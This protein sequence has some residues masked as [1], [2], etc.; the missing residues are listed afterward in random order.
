M[1][2]L[3]IAVSAWSFVYGLIHT[4]QPCEDKAIFG[5]HTFGVAK[6]SA[7]AFK[8]VGIYALGLMTVNN[9]IGF[10]FSILGNFF[11][12]IP[13][14]EYFVEYLSPVLSIFLGCY[15]YYRLVKLNRPDNHMA[16][17]LAM[18]VRKNLL[19]VF[20]LG[21]ITGIPPCP[22][23]F[24]IYFQA[25]TAAGGYLANGVFHVLW[26]SL[27]TVSGLMVLTLIIRSFKRLERLRENQVLQKI[28]M[29]ILI[30]FGVASLVLKFFGIEFFPQPEPPIV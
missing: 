19:G 6:N 18:K 9:V 10:G 4:I 27:G 21:I 15:L 8:I 26:F 17:P 1:L 13:V 12:V 3:L 29:I 24:A 28:A 16:S 7:E 5:F 2:Q 20:L 14:I 25:F 11:S 22:F 30:V 23:E